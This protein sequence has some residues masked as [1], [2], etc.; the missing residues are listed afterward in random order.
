VYS[1]L[2]S[3]NITS[4]NDDISPL[5]T[6]LTN[7]NLLPNT[8]YLGIVQFGT[9]TFHATSNV[10]FSASNYNLTV[11]KGIKKSS[12]LGGAAPN[13]AM[14]VLLAVAGVMAML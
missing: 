7:N 13:L 1:W 8:T 14:V 3:S 12:A 6:Y 11:V 5:F 2:A 4:F 9:E 10:T